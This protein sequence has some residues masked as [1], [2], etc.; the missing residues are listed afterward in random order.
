MILIVSIMGALQMFV[1][2]AIGLAFLKL[3]ISVTDENPLDLISRI[4]SEFLSKR[5]G[6]ERL[7]ALLMA[8]I[9]L[10]AMGAGTVV[11]QVMVPGAAPQTIIALATVIVVA[12]IAIILGFVWCVQIVTSLGRR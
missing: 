11:S 3:Y 8:L 7:N 10:L 2:G 12:I 1:V 6:P 4:V 9:A 5:W